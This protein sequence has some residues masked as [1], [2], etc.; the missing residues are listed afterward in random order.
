MRNLIY[1][2]CFYQEGYVDIVKNFIQTIK[3]Y[4]NDNTDLLIY[5]T[6]QFKD[7]INDPSVKYFEKNFYKTMN[8]AR[9]S[10]MDIFDYPEIDN[11]SKVLYLDADSYAIGPVE[12]I[13]DAI[14]ENVVYTVGEGNILCEAEYWGRSLFLR[15]NADT[16]DR[17]GLGAYALGF[18]N[19]PELK[20]LF[21]KIKQAFY[22]DMYQNKLRFYDQPFLNY[23]LINNAMCDT[24][25]FKKFI[26]SRPTAEDAIKSNVIVAHFSGCPGHADVKIGLINEF[27]EQLGKFPL[28]AAVSLPNVPSSAVHLN[29]A[30]ILDAL[31][32]IKGLV[33]SIESLM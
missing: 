25:T 4:L 14:Q 11:Y 26:R 1:T 17:E 32:K 27:K 23:Y 2:S 29:K 13:F 6:S 31:N 16:Q 24:Q 10:K 19:L 15:E 12:P 33:A 3:P 8:Q 5:T 22:L 30:E 28:S 9:I 7:L 21:I 20:K 18:K